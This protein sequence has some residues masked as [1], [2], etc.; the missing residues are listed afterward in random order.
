MP[1]T[2]FK[3]GTYKGKSFKFPGRFI[4]SVTIQDGKISGITVERH[5]ALRKYTRMLSPLIDRMMEN[6][7]ADVD[8][9]T[10]ATISSRSLQ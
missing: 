1:D 8:V 7:H 3:D 9:V 5:L 6:K 10:G 2:Q 4:A